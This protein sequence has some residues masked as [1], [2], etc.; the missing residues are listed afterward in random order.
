V[1]PRKLNVTALA[2][3]R[4]DPRIQPGAPRL[5][6][7]DRDGLSI[8]PVRSFVGRRTYQQDRSGAV[9]IV[10]A[11]ALPVLLGILALVAE[12]GNLL[13]VKAQY[14]RTADLASYAGA[15]AYSATNANAAMEDAAINIARLNGVD[16]VSVS[17]VASPR[18]AERQAVRAT[19][20]AASPL[21]LAPILGANSSV[22]VTSVAYA[23]IG[24]QTS[25][26]IL[27]VND[28]LAG[29]TLSGGA[30]IVAPTCL[31]ASNAKVVAPCGTTIT[32]LAVAYNSRTAPYQ[33]CSGI[34]AG[35]IL[36]GVTADPLLGNSSVAAATARLDTVAAMSGPPTPVV[37]TGPNIDFAYDQSSTIAQAQ[38]AGCA[39]V[40]N[41]GTWTLTCPSGGNYRFG[42]IT[43][44]GGINVNFNT[45]GSRQTTY[46]F[47]G[48]I[49][50][51][52]AVLTFGDGIYN[53][54]NG[55][56]TGGGSTT[57][58]GA[59]VFKLGRSVSPCSGNGYYSICNTSNLSFGG[60]STFQF[61]AG[62]RN[63]GG[64]TLNL[65]YGANISANSFWVGAAS[66]GDAFT[67]GGGSKTYLGD[68]TGGSS[69]FKFAGD[70]NDAGGG[71]CLVVSAA[72]QHDVRGNFNASGAVV[73]GAGIYSIDGYM[74]LGAAGGGGG[75]C[76]GA[77]VSVRGRDVSIVVSGKAT[78]SSGACHGQAYCVASGYNNVVLTAPTSGATASLAV[79]GPA[80][81][82][83]KA[84][85]AFTQGGSSGQI[86]GVFYFPNG[87]VALSGGASL[88]GSGCL[89]LIGSHIALSGG[90]TLAS[91]CINGGASGRVALVQ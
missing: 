44:G 77:N 16:S 64:S 20:S 48:S 61:S 23:E 79:I 41:N 50:N 32:A 25:S 72:A 12:Y 11:V 90:A 37:A 29:I 47:S 31:V 53:I 5:V 21:F 14:Q 65:G 68:A 54:A 88:S 81:P 15:L 86:T 49:S 40:F 87:P 1:T 43:L 42:N 3:Y 46:N 70:I 58:F 80:S 2:K 59:G 76:N 74:A 85:A 17:L 38:S 4:R 26:C 73:L 18:T 69:V 22:D 57:R 33:P 27:A 63:T 84:G 45:A 39:A 13:V 28:A 35:T 66:T 10:F 8:P 9:A 24:A 62:I 60:P 71:G 51:N 6:R 83:N 91:A 75:A 89:Q 82:N 36:N 78:P 56:S 19:I 30:S 67:M 55:I 7:L 34:T 52:G